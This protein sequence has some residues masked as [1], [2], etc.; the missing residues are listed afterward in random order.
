MQGSM[1]AVTRVTPSAPPPGPQGGRA[2][3]V[4]GGQAAS[5]I[6]RSVHQMAVDVVPVDVV[7]EAGVRGDV[8]VALVVHRVD[9]RV[10][11]GRRHVVVDERVEQAAL[12]VETR[13]VHRAE[14]VEIA[15]ATAV[16]LEVHAERFGSRDA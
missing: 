3:A 4:P 10:E 13:E 12:I 8:D 9:Q 7:A 5:A 11:P 16:D 1:R 14:H 6:W 15:D 2:L